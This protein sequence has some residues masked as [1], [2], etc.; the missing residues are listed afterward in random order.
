MG[1]PDGSVVKSLPGIAGDTDL[2]PDPGKSHI[3]WG[4]K[5]EGPQPLSLCSRLQELQLL[6]PR[7]AAA[8]DVCT[9]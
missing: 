5:A 3:L 6:S 4:K 7:A 9:P 1:L 8:A 2:I